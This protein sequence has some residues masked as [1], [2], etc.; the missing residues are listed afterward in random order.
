MARIFG[1]YPSNTTAI[2]TQATGEHS[3]RLNYAC[4]AKLLPL[5]QVKV[6]HETRHH[7][8]ETFL[9]G[10]QRGAKWLRGR[11]ALLGPQWLRA[12]DN[13]SRTI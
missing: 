2:E 1:L 6:P 13:Q 8:G 12:V 11:D 4:A 5:I 3:P 10:W 9:R 7:T